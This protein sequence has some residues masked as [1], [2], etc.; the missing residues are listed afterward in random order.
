MSTKQLD[1]LVLTLHHLAQKVIA[2][3]KKYSS[4]KAV[5]MMKHLIN[6]LKQ[7]IMQVDPHVY[8]MDNSNQRLVVRDC[9]YLF[10]ANQ[11]NSALSYKNSV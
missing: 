7:V 8:W 4:C 9:K 3:P 1:H 10:Q 11:L 2:T 6:G 5:Y